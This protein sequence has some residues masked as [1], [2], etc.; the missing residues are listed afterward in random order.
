MQLFLLLSTSIILASGI[1]TAIE[2]KP[3]G[4]TRVASLFQGSD[5]LAQRRQRSNVAKQGWLQQRR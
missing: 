5:T 3:S 1:T 4:T 2:V